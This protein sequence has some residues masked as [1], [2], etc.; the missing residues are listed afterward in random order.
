MRRTPSLI[1]LIVAALTALPAAA[2]ATILYDTGVGFR[3]P[4]VFIFHG[5]STTPQPINLPTF[6]F[7]FGLCPAVGTHDFLCGR[8]VS[9]A[10]ISNG[11]FFLKSAARFKHTDADVNHHETAAYADTTIEVSGLTGYVGTAPGA[12]FYFGLSGQRSATTNNG[13]VMIQA[14]GV[15]RLYAGNGSPS[16]QCVAD[17]DC[18]PKPDPYKLVVHQF[19]LSDGFRVNLRSDVAAVAPFGTSGYDAEVIADFAD[20]LE[21]LAIQLLDENDDPIPGVAL[22]ATDENG[23][24]V[25]T[26]ANEPPTATP[27]PI[28]TVTPTPTATATSTNATATPTPTATV[29]GP[30]PTP[31]PCASPPCE[32]CE[33][34]ID[35]DGD[36]AIDGADSDCPVANGNGGGYGNDAGKAL[37]KC[38][39]AVR[40][41]GLKLASADSKLIQSCIKAVADCVQL[42]P[43]VA[44]CLTGAQAKCAKA[45]ATLADGSA[46][47][48]GK[49]QKACVSS[50][51]G[52]GD[53]TFAGGLGFDAEA[54][55]CARRG[56][57]SLGSLTDVVECV[58]RQHACVVDRMIGV[59]IPRARELL[60]LGGWDSTEL[61]CLDAGTDGGGSGVTADKRKAL[62]KCDGTLQKAA[63]KLVAARAKSVQAC[64]AAV[65]T[66]VQTKPGD[67]GCTDKA[68]ATCTKGT[69][70]VSSLRATFTDAVAKACTKAPL[71][72]ADLFGPTGL[73]A[74]ALAP[75]CSGLGVPS[76]T[77]SADLASCVLRSLECRAD[78]LLENESPR[79]KELL[80]IGTGS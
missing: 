46:K 23:Q 19:R 78:Q 59:T 42:K 51:F 36:L 72:P 79:L 17:F 21:L 61:S 25:I 49:I 34:C 74:A 71:E 37:D 30:T 32:D 65:F 38:A 60:T 18:I 16:V 67:A 41:V 2:H 63:A 20:T 58:R 70:A 47:V 12:A 28:P 73:G 68:R 44:E 11:R 53:F 66:C 69:D 54:G 29:T 64:S 76:L 9:D 43:G 50:S 1:L 24:P 27:T 15:A 35:D 22:T 80:Q 55:T 77:T 7:G 26:F 48:D 3:Q 40:G 56:V 62:R 14:F 8:L 57:A 33:N 13:N 5:Q 4:E 75:T 6:S 10:G 45:R 31:A 39:K 52:F